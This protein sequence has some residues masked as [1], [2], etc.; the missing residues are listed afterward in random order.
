M[1]DRLA[2]L[3][4]TLATSTAAATKHGSEDVSWVHTAAA[5]ALLQALFTILVVYLTFLFVTQHFVSSSDLFELVWVATLVWMLLQSLFVIGFLDL[6]HGRIL[7]D[8]ENFIVLSGVDLLLR[9]S[10]HAWVTATMPRMP[11]WP[12]EVFKID[13][14]AKHIFCVF[15]GW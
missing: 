5:S 8:S 10:A 7:L 6:T 9:A 13:T 15:L 2:L 11:G 1:L 12:E 3:R 4:A 14:A